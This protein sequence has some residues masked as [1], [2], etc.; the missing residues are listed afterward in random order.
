MHFPNHLAIAEQR[1]LSNPSVLANS[2]WESIYLE[3]YQQPKFKI[4]V[5]KY[6]ACHSLWL[7]GV[8]NG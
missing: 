1:H 3:F 5:R 2:G 6:D 4:A 7:N 8:D